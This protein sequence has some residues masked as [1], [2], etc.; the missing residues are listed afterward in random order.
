MTAPPQKSPR[1]LFSPASAEERAR[2]GK[3]LLWALPVAVGV[4]LM[5]ALLG[6]DADTIERK[7]TPYGATG[8]LRLMPEISIE[9]SDDPE[10][11]RA[12][13]Q[14][15]PPPAAPRY[16]VEP[17]D[18]APVAEEKAPLHRDETSEITGMGE[19]TSQLEET[20]VA[21]AADGDAAVD[22]DMPSQ[23][24]DS[25]FIIRKLVRPLYPPGASEAD[26]RKPV[27][28]VQAAFFLN[29]QAEIVAVMIQSNDGGPEFAAEV[30]AAMEQWE[31]EPRLRD[32]QPPAPRW[33]VVTW[34]F[35]S[36]FSPRAAP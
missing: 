28:T 8:P 31:F 35:R 24:V 30:Q 5:L 6:P 15:D 29:E 7:F 9:D 23:Q 20:D 17:E 13:V 10:H 12:A 19:A 1:R 33:L 22:M 18:F 16:Q 14:A 25:D 32:G 27:V 4:L 11:Q 34:R 2:A 36:P 21:I 26:R 3:R